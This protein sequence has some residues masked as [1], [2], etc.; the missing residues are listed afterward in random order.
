VKRGSRGAWVAVVAALL[1]MPLVGCPLDPGPRAIEYPVDAEAGEIPFRF[2]GRGEAALLVSVEI[3]GEGPF[4]FVLD[5]GATLTCVDQTIAERL[6][7]PARRG[8]VGVGAGIEGAGRI[9]LVTLDSLRLGGAAASA[10][11]A[12][13]LDLAHTEVIGVGIDG[14]LGLN[15]LRQFRVTLD[16]G[17]N[18]LLLEAP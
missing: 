6:Q 7:L 8:A 14:L 17:R 3:N 16:F 4:D 10:L 15:F 5:T 13:V 1:T 18:V 9:G 12:C 11:D 2:G